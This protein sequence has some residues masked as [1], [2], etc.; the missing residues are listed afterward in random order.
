[1]DIYKMTNNLNIPTDLGKGSLSST[2]L[3]RDNISISDK[4]YWIFSDFVL[5]IEG[6][7]IPWS[8]TLAFLIL[9]EI[10]KKI[11]FHKVMG[12]EYMTRLG[13]FSN[14]DYLIKSYIQIF[15][16]I[17][18]LLVGYSGSIYTYFYPEVDAV[19][20]SSTQHGWVW[21]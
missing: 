1:M 11:K 2:L 12:M 17:I 6:T 20:L 10:H 18:G 4:E 7:S 21:I 8:P 5:N 13:R 9:V 14:A 16:L 15:M 19:I 3:G